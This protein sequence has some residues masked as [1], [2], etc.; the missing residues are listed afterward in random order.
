MLFRSL[1]RAYF[2]RITARKIALGGA[3]HSSNIDWKKGVFSCEKYVESVQLP[4]EMKSVAD[5]QVMLGDS[6]MNKVMDSLM[7]IEEYG[8]AAK[9][10]TTGVWDTEVV[11]GAGFTKWS[12]AS[13]ATPLDDIR[14]G[15]LAIQ[16]ATGIKPNKL[17]LG[18]TAAYALFETDDVTARIKTIPIINGN[19]MLLAKAGPMAL[20]AY[21]GLDEVL[22]ADTIVNTAAEN[23]SVG[24][25]ESN[26]WVFADNAL[27]C[28][29]APALGMQIP[30]A[31]MTTVWRDRKSVG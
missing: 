23:N 9:F 25:G 6:Q 17:V 30:T 3:I 22:I 21:L 31:M 16:L 1:K 5:P 10:F 29:A 13:S 18:V 7:L 24:G 14:T 20:A 12:S 2:N 11:G 27:L 19:Q 4:F 15:I 8:W 28:Y 26:S